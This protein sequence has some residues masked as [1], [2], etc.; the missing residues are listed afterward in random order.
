MPVHFT[1]YPTR[2][3]VL[4]RF[5]GHILMADCLSSAK[6]Y[7]EHPDYNPLQNQLIDLSGV[8]SHERDFVRMMST[9]AAMPDHLLKPGTYPLII[10]IAPTEVAKEI[11]SFVLRSMAGLDRTPV[12]VVECESQALEI[13]GQPERQLAEI[14]AGIADR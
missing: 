9:L 13:L 5:T 4:A 2:G 10:Y 1:V 7:T 6:A 14:D 12:R 8:T 3:F 11:T